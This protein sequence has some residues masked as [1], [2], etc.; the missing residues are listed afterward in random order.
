MIYEFKTPE[1]WN[2]AKEGNPNLEGYGSPGPVASELGITR[3]AVYN[4]VK[5][6]KLDMVRITPQRFNQVGI[7]FI[8]KASV[9]RYIQTAGTSGRRPSRQAQVKLLKDCFLGAR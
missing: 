6:G 5:R 3:Q 9:E 7:I 4:A 2:A 1:E 8:T